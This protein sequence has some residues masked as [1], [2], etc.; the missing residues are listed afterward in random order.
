M[1]AAA[2]SCIGFSGERVK[3]PSR[4][5]GFLEG[6]LFWAS[7]SL[8]AT[9]LG[10]PRHVPYGTAIRALVSG[11]GDGAQQDFLR[12]LTGQFG[13]RLYLDL[14]LDKMK[15]PIENI[16][17]AEDAARRAHAW[18]EPDKPPVTAYRDWHLA[19]ENLAADIYATWDATPGFVASLAARILKSRVEATWVVATSTLTYSYGLN[20]LLSILVARLHAHRTGRDAYHA[21]A[22]AVPANEVVLF[23]FELDSV[24]PTTAGSHACGS[25]C[26]GHEHEVFV[27][28]RSH[29]SKPISLGTFDVIVARHG[30]D[31]NPLFAPAPVSEQLVPYD[32]PR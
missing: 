25:G 5:G 2:V 11:S 26:Y 3:V 24:Q 14:G 9:D 8:D 6:P 31:Q 29:R 1:F 7:D 12:I 22:G 10:V 27:R 21:K 17:L 15:L 19:Y 16:L 28:G 4:S 13:K 32:L 18:S 30:V 20:R 23:G